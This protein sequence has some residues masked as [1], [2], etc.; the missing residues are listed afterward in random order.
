LAQNEQI[1]AKAMVWFRR[2]LRT[3]DHATFYHALKAGRARAAPVYW[4]D[5]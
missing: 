4:R 2:D 5:A 3:H 1:Y